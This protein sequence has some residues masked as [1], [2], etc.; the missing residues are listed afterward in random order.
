MPSCNSLSR[1]R[2]GTAV[3]RIDRQRMSRSQQRVGAVGLLLVFARRGP[4]IGSWVASA[5]LRLF[6][7]TISVATPSTSW[8]AANNRRTINK[9][10]VTQRPMKV[11][12]S[13]SLGAADSTAQ[14]H[15]VLKGSR[16]MFHMSAVLALADLIK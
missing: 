6:E 2:R 10:L 5:R 4:H 9:V 11:S 1:W 3:D 15:D 8:T 16:L 14:G 13:I 12:T 7:V